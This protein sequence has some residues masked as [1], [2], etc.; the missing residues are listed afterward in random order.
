MLVFSW[1]WRICCISV[2][3][4]RLYFVLPNIFSPLKLTQKIVWSDEAEL[5]YTLSRMIQSKGSTHNTLV[6]YVCC[7]HMLV[8]C[9]CGKRKAR[10]PLLIWIIYRRSLI[11]ALQASATKPGLGRKFTFQ[12]DSDPKHKSK[13]IQKHL[14]M[15]TKKMLWSGHL[16]VCESYFH[17]TSFGNT[18]K[19]SCVIEINS[20]N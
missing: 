20:N 12:H 1:P 15:R 9:T 13:L 8:Y 14:D 3:N 4:Q 11:K 17:G 10:R 5:Y 7:S 6:Y 19:N 2:L 16:K 18:E